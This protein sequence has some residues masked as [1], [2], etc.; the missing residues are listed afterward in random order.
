MEP[1]LLTTEELLTQE[2]I[3]QLL[4]HI[5]EEETRTT[6][7]KTG[8]IKERQLN[9]AIRPCDF[10]IPASSSSNDLRKLRVQHNEFLQAL[11]A[12]LSIY[13]RLEFALRMARFETVP[14]GEFTGSLADTHLTLFKAE[15]CRGVCILEITPSL[16]LAIVDR[17]MG[18]PGQ[19]AVAS[20]ELSEI[21]SALLD[22]AI[23][24][25]VSEWCNHWSQLQELRPVLLGHET[26]GRFLHTA[27]M[28]SAVLVLGMEARVGDCVEQLQI[29]FPYSTIESLTG[30]L[31]PSDG[32][33]EPTATVESRPIWNPQLNDVRV[34]VTAEWPNMQLSARELTRLKVGDVLE[35]SP[36]MA[37][38][39]RLRLARKARF[40]G[41]LGTRGNKWAVELTQVLNPSSSDE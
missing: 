40:V 12:R 13:L 30:R 8:G 26:S 32:E 17:L 33:Q 34:P 2:Q 15:P 14:Y 19:P 20:R 6:V 7:H 29:G 31:S 10:R 38:Q 41:R 3:E 18:G 22:Q 9:D 24:I 16:G 23:Q 1:S 39:V 37:G 25:I 28:D 36:E 35:W 27:P 4:A 5:A 21:E 11:A